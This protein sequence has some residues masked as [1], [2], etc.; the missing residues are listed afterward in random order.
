M[1]SRADPRSAGGT[2][3]VAEGVDATARTARVVGG[4]T[5]TAGTA[6]LT[7]EAAAEAAG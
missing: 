1:V 7:A 6:A 4:G 2:T 3:L 5:A